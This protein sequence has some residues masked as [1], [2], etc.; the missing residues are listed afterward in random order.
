[1]FKGLDSEK[2]EL[3]LFME[4]DFPTLPSA[5]QP[6]KTLILRS[7]EPTALGSRVLQPEGGIGITSPFL[8]P[9]GANS[10]S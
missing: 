4:G 2:C 5:P 10:V 7:G 1:M 3:S 6:L 9:E 8:F